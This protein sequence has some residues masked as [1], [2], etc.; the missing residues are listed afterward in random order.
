MNST[1]LTTRISFALCD[2]TAIEIDVKVIA[3][4]RRSGERI[5]VFFRNP[6][7]PCE[8]SILMM[9]IRKL[10]LQ[11]AQMIYSVNLNQFTERDGASCSE[12]LSIC[13]I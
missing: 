9:K 6:N 1:K 10:Q 11:S 2:D 13:I 3:E 7:E 4:G 12:Q 8:T 5:R